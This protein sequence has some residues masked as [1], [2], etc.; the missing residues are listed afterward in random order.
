MKKRV[1]SA[2]LCAMMIATMA[3]GCGSKDASKD[4]GSDDKGKIVDRR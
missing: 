2:F 1:L 3:V 4:A